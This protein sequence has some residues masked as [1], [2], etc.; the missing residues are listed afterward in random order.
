VIK[1]IYLQYDQFQDELLWLRRTDRR[2]GILPRE[3]VAG[4]RLFD[5]GDVMMATF[6]K[7]KVD[8]PFQGHHYAYLQLL[9]KGGLTLYVF[10]KS[11][12]KA[13]ANQLVEKSTYF[14]SGNGKDYLLRLSRKSLLNI[15]AVDHVAMKTVLHDSRLT[16]NNNEEGLIQAIQRYNQIIP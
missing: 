16:I 10:R 7:R 2:T 5:S 14:I 6:V 1:N 15:P 12:A 13:S 3:A 4:F 8:L 9:A 11:T